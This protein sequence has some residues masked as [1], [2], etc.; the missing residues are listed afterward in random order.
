MRN[1]LSDL[2]VNKRRGLIDFFHNRNR[3]YSIDKMIRKHNLRVEND[4][5]EAAR[6]TRVLAR[7][8]KTRL[9]TGVFP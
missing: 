1:F 4:A 3:Q 6:L 5:Q 2:S 7:M 9:T 8:T